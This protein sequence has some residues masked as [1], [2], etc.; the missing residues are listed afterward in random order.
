MPRYVYSLL[1]IAAIFLIRL[2]LLNAFTPSFIPFIS[3]IS[4]SL[5]EYTK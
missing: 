1:L 2:F 5:K 3:S 4:Q